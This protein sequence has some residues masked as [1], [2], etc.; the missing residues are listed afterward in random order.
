MWTPWGALTFGFASW[1]KMSD[2]AN[3]L[4][5]FY[6]GKG[7]PYVVDLY[8]LLQSIPLL[9]K[10]IPN[11]IGKTMKAAE[12]I[13][14]QD[15]GDKDADVCW[16]HQ[17]EEQG[18]N[19]EDELSVLQRSRPAQLA[20]FNIYRHVYWT[21]AA[22]KKHGTSHSMRLLF[23]IRDVFDM[24]WQGGVDI[25]FWFDQTM[26]WGVP[27]P[28]MGCVAA[29]VSWKQGNGCFVEFKPA[30][31]LELDVSGC[32]GVTIVYDAVDTVEC[33]KINGY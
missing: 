18:V 33:L 28:L 22:V 2:N 20:F 21:Q 30:P 14:C 32:K 23:G 7:E 4:R 19:P 26:G 6:T 31:S 13:C 8:R 11:A 9:Q 25:P 12:Q 1:I 17:V 16:I 5:W 29:T 27:Y 15:T 3:Q 24:H 10:E